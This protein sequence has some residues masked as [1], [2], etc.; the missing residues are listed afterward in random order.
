MAHHK[1]HP[2]EVRCRWG[3]MRDG[4]ITAVEAEVV[5]DGGAYA[6]TSA[7]VIKVATFFCQRLLRGP[8][9]RRGWLRRLHQ[10][11]PVGAFRGFGAP[12]AQFASEVMV[13]RLAEALGMDPVELR[14]R[15]IYREGSIEPTQQPLPPGR[16]CPGR[17]GALRR[18][19]SRQAGLRRVPAQHPAPHLRRGMGIACGIKN[20]GYSFGYP[21]AGHGHGGAFGRAEYERAQVRVGAADVG[22]GRT[23][24][25][26]RSPPRP[27][28]CRS[29]AI[30]DDL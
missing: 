28:T 11:R 1:R 17:A 8:Q 14:R 5:A 18:G 15:N 4:R 26:A 6:S 23:W 3:A 10:Q 19:G 7:E 9:H 29:Q 12:Q 22:Q 2:M 25:C 20:V 21:G 30:D 24:P 16:Q 13:T 27:W